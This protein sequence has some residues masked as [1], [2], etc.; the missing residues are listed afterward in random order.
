MKT[1]QLPTLS[2]ARASKQQQ[3]ARRSRRDEFAAP[4]QSR[5]T[6]SLPTIGHESAAVRAYDKH[7]G[8]ISD[9]VADDGRGW[10]AR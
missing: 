8:E 1:M 4:R 7:Y 2:G 3:A 9:M 10:R 6:R 5:H